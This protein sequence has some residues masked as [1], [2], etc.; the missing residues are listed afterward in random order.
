MRKKR[1]LHDDLPPRSDPNY[2]KLYREKNKDRMNEQTKSWYLQKK[3]ENPNFGK[4]VYDPI[5]A[6]RYRENN[7]K[8]FREH[9]WR[10]HGIKNFSHEQYLC[11]LDKQRNK[12]MICE[13]V[14]SVPQ[15]DHDHATGNYRGILCKPCNFG[16]GIYEK[17]KDRFGEYLQKF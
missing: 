15:V 8:R 2:M 7:R 16:L 3:K 10:R 4:E 1:E 6:A 11:E 13:E 5:K 9:N 14:M 12:C 17:N